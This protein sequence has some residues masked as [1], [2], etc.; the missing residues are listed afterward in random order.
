MQT[1]QQQLQDKVNAALT[2]L[3]TDT[4]A[5]SGDVLQVVPCANPQ[6]GDYQFNGALPLAKAAK[7]NPRA[8]AQSLLEKLDAGEI[9]EAPEIAGPGFI[10]FRLKREFLE[11][12]AAQALAD[13]RLGVPLA[14]KPRTV[15]VDYP[16]PNVAKPLH[17]GHIRTMFIGDAIARTLR[18]A[19]HKVIADDHIGDWGT[20]IGMVIWGWPRFGDENAMQQNALEAMGHVYKVVKG[21]TTEKDADGKATPQAKETLAAVREETAKLHRGDEQTLALWKTLRDA[22]QVEIDAV[23][24][25]LGIKVDVALGESFYHPRLPGIVEELKAKGLA[26]ESEG[27]QIIRFEEPPHLRDKPMLVQKSDGSFLYATTDLATIQYR[28]EKWQPDEILYVVGAPQADHFRQLFAATKLW[29]LENVAFKHISFGTVLGEDGTPLKSRTG[30]SPKLSDLLE[31]AQTR[32]RAIAAEK[33][34]NL[35]EAQLDEISRVIGIGAL[36]YADLA[37]NRVSDYIFS[38]DKM[39]AMQGNSAPYLIYAYVRIRSIFR[40]A[41]ESGLISE[42][43]EKFTLQEAAEIELVKFLLRFPLVI[44]TA[45]ADYRVNAVSDYLFELSSKFSVFF[46][47]CPVLKSE[48]PLRESRLALCD[49]TS[50]VL[51]QGLNLLGIET[52]EQM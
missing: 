50:R 25:E 18:F 42:E 38:W 43:T 32:A 11:N 36:K 12:M 47:Q 21:M 30:E 31:E 41:Q 45:L 13:E 44:D 9:S 19:G 17:V 33:N 14:E 34:P 2:A 39:L 5:V 27:A 22:S 4:S 40:R 28:M 24:A 15:V 52:V 49:L 26:V 46:E 8:L 35:S 10:N 51:K 7:S 23:Y 20:P 37:Q 29:G 3:N 16:S 6:H 1:V 48:S